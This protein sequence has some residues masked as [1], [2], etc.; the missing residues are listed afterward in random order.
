MRTNRTLTVLALA[1]ALAACGRGETKPDE[2]G[3]RMARTAAEQPE[4]APRPVA[5][6]RTGR[7]DGLEIMLTSVSADKRPERSPYVQKLPPGEVYVSVRYRTRNVS[8]QAVTGRDR[9]T[10]VLRD[11]ADRPY[12]IDHGVSVDASDSRVEDAGDADINPEIT[13]DS[14]GVWRVKASAFDRATWTVSFG[15][16]QPVTFALK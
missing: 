2:R 10:V 8:G 15:D 12:L 16:G 3:A 7:I 11:G 9:P 4:E 6:G 5:F 1:G 13:V 14:L